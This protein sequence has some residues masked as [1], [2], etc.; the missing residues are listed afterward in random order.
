MLQRASPL[1]PTPI[2]WAD[3]VRRVD[4]SKEWKVSGYG[5]APEMMKVFRDEGLQP[6]TLDHPNNPATLRM[7]E[8]ALKSGGP[9]LAAIYFDSRA[10]G[11]AGWAH[12]GAQAAVMDTLLGFCNA[13][14]NSGGPTLNLSIRFLQPA[15]LNASLRADA[16]LTALERKKIFLKGMLADPHDPSIVYAEVDGLW[17]NAFS[18]DGPGRKFVPAS[19][20]NFLES[21]KGLS[22]KHPSIKLETKVD[23]V[24]V[25]W[26]KQMSS[27]QVCQRCTDLFTSPASSLGT[28]F[29]TQNKRIRVEYFV[30]RD[31]FGA[32][33]SVSGECMGPPP[34]I[35]GGCIFSLHADAVVSCMK[36]RAHS[37][38]V[39][40]S[41]GSLKALSVNFRKLTP[42]WI[43]YA[44]HVHVVAQEKG[45]DSDTWRF[46]LS[47]EMINP[48]TGDVHSDAQSEF[49]CNAHGIHELLPSDLIHLAHNQ[50]ASSL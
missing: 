7:Y 13:A 15:P 50:T 4:E 22:S 39:R 33:I 9:V 38:G 28:A 2:A 29:V 40:T 3:W 46:V 26:V 16:Q 47:S 10:E 17:F 14:N 19:S 41:R 35:H 48:D 31:L 27:Q 24:E 1:A 23:L 30:S 32:V 21:I 45:T 8:A 11:A 34:N 42:L 49:E 6:F 36:I 25:P 44:L 18:A 12:E 5:R 43:T 20:P 37:L